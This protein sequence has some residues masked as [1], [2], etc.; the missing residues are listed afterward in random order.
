MSLKTALGWLK[1]RHNL[2][3]IRLLKR[4]GKKAL[5]APWASGQ[6]SQFTCI[7]RHHTFDNIFL[8]AE[9]GLNNVYKED[10]LIHNGFAI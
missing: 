10:S 9:V 3:N 6:R 2:L 8:P 4:K 5:W 7:K 1:P